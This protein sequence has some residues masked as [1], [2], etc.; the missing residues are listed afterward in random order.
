[1]THAHAISCKSD[2]V[3]FY[4]QALM[5]NVTVWILQLVTILFVANSLALA[6]DWAH[7][8]ADIIIM[9][10]TFQIFSA[11]L[12]DT[13]KDH[14]VKKKWLVRIAVIMLWLSAFWI[15]YEAT[16]RMAAPVDFPGWPVAILALLSTV[17]NFLAHKRIGC[18]DLCEHDDAHRINVAHLL[19][20]A[21]ISLIVFVSAMGKILFDLPAIDTW[22]GIFVG[23]WMIYLG[24]KILLGKGGH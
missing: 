8:F 18:V 1:M 9:V 7:G 10:A 15:F 5:I 23:I 13:E 19:T 2:K 3:R 11:E 16:E 6:G 17:G 21:V 12:H 14:S 4:Q 20:D 22:L 24:W